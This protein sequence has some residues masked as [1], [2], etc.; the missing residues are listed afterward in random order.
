MFTPSF[1]IITGILLGLISIRTLY[2]VI[3][4]RHQLF[5]EDFTPTDRQRLSE[6]AFFILLP[7]SVIFHEL[8]HAAV[9]LGVG[10][11]ITGYGWYF[12]YGFVEYAG[13]VTPSQIFWIALAGNLVSLFLG[14]LA[15]A[16]PAFWPRR[17]PVNYLLFVFGALSIVN[18]LV[19]YPLLDLVGGFG[20]DWSQIYSGATPLLSRVTGVIHVS[21]V[22][23]A[24]LAWRSQRGRALYATRTGLSAESMRRVS[25]SQAANELLSAGEILASSWKHPLRVVSGAQDKNAASVTLHWVSNGYG[26]VVA[27]Y[28][29]T[30]GSRH[31]EIHGAIRQLEPNGQSFQQPLALIQGIPSPDHVIPAL[32]QALNTVDT[33]DMSTLPQP[34]THS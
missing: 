8:G 23:A 34:A 3:R 5:D 6:A 16:I 22:V 26:R 11:H 7:V 29:V 27:I 14:L 10:A 2:T 13:F 12:F 18:S 28:A 25:L 19:F 17:A 30:T 33:W 21:F 9:I 4:D 20:G 15:I 32:T 24:V 1:M 31:I